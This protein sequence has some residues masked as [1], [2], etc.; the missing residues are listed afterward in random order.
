MSKN[1]RVSVI[2]LTYNDFSTLSRCIDSI[3]IQD[4]EDIEIVIQDDGSKNFDMN[5]VETELQYKKN[6]IKN[7]IV[8]HNK[9]NVGTV[10]NYNLAV[11]CS[12]GEYIVP[13]ASDDQFYDS[14]VIS[15]IVNYFNKENCNVCTALVKGELSHYVFPT[16]NEIKLFNY[17]NIQMYK[18]HLFASN[19]ICGAALYWKKKYLVDIGYFDESFV[20][21]EDYPIVLHLIELNQQVSFMKKITVIHGENGISTRLNTL[22][23]K[24]KLADNDAK[25]IKDKYV[26]PN[27]DSIS[28]YKIKRYI[29]ACYYLKFS[30]NKTEFL[31]KFIKYIDVWI[32]VFYY[33]IWK[34]IH[35]AANIS[36][37]EYK[38][39]R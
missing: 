7:I 6:N 15:N 1:K 21:V 25:K 30:R 5:I 8:N 3:F 17:E 34:K 16:N 19:F 14:G 12:T 11:K 13:L 20:L 26:L 22:L 32:S 29:L 23:K 2:V 39:E 27:I 28:N 35:K 36:Y 31:K 18:E 33:L 37:F 10:K 4:Y 38:F 9:K 24:N